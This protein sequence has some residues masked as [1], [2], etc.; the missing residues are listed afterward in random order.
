[1]NVFILVMQFKQAQM[2][3]WHA[4]WH[5]ASDQACLYQGCIFQQTDLPLT[6]DPCPVFAGPEDTPYSGGCFE[7]DIYFPTT[8]PHVPMNVQIRTTGEVRLH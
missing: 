2:T 8:Y 1:M 3:L 7:F 5:A 4:Y 6:I